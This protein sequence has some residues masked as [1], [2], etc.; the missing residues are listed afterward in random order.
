MAVV[1]V[2]EKATLVF[3]PV[4]GVFFVWFCFL[5][6]AAPQPDNYM[7]EGDTVVT[8]GDSAE[9]GREKEAP[10]E[11]NK[12]RDYTDGSAKSSMH[13]D[14]SKAIAVASASKATTKKSIPTSVNVVI[15]NTGDIST[16][17][18]EENE[19]VTSLHLVIQ[20]GGDTSTH[21]DD[22]IERKSVGGG[23]IGIVSNMT[24][25]SFSREQGNNEDTIV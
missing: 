4:F 8:T 11:K 16:H 14:E 25:E 17:G 6:K 12:D 9:L 24:N 13:I 3:L 22:K 23:A 1:N 2:L 19:S 5:R 15:Q 10:V 21:G 20:N 7:Y 18:D